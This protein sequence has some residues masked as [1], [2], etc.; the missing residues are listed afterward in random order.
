MSLCDA[1]MMSY[2]FGGK[3][4]YMCPN[5]WVETPHSE[6]ISL[7]VHSQTTPTVSEILTPG[8]HHDKYVI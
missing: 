5:V 4:M 7:C 2:S 1:V 6:Y 3:P 8:A